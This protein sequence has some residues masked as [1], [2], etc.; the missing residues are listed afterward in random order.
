MIPLLDIA[1]ILAALLLGYLL[2]LLLFERGTSYRTSE[3]VHHLDD[4]ERLRILMTL[5]GTPA[6]PIG[7]LHVLREGAELYGSQIADVRAAKHSVHL[8]AYIFYP[9]QSADALLEALCERA[10]A[11]VRVRVIIDAIGSLRTRR[12]HFAALIAAGGR[13]Y[14]YHPL[15]WQMFRR[16]NSRTH[17]NLLVL[18]GTVAYIGGAGVADHW[19]RTEPPPWRDCVARVTGP[20]VSGLQAVF[21]ENWLECAGELL[22]GSEA[23]PANTSGSDAQQDPFAI[24]MAV[25][26]TPTAGGSTRARVLVQFLLATARERID[27]CSPYFIPDLGIRRELLAA[28][29]R[30]VRV[31]ILTGGPYSDH[32]IVRRAGRRRYGPLLEA[33][34]EISE[35]SSNMMHAKLLIVDG[36]WTLLGSTNIDHRSF[37]LNDEVNLLVLSPDLGSQ[38]QDTFEEDLLKSEIL[39]LASWRSRS[40]RERVLAT[41]GRLIERHQ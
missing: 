16:W 29:K 8:E 25:G 14:R 3:A 1:A 33:G 19:S 38:L 20:I 9:G 2:F 18:D 41:L 13:V 22:V 10:N 17:R 5:L 15:R 40:W 7:S 11:G 35:Y 28:R 31:R 12:A 36:C 37:G 26:S 30:G 4:A 39:D 34:V 24:G 6:Q 23:L 27:L 32:G 21:A